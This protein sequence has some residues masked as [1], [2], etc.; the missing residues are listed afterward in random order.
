M[1][2]FGPSRLLYFLYP[3]MHVF[4]PD[5]L[6]PAFFLPNLPENEILN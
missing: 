2:T 5:F 3:N 4:K 1:A 6:S